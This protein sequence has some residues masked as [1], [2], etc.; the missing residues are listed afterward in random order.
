MRGRGKLRLRNLLL[1]ASRL[2][3]AAGQLRPHDGRSLF[4]GYDDG[5]VNVWHV[6]GG[7][8][9]RTMRFDRSG[10]LAFGPDGRW[11]ASR[12]EDDAEILD[13]NDGVK[14]LRV[15]RLQ[16]HGNFNDVTTAAF[17]PDGR[18]L[19]STDEHGNI[20]IWDVSTGHM[21]CGD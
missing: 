18:L 16:G 17:S 7:L 3:P 12:D 11:I 15:F 13:L 9:V 6:G 14:G 19:A 5:A 1:Q 4:T 8:P 2:L 20:I 10:I 21:V